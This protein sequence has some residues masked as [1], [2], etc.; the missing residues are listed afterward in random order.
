MDVIDRELQ[1]SGLRMHVR[2]WGGEGQPV[3]LVHGLAS[4]ARIWDLTAPYMIAAGLRVVAVDQRGHGQTAKPIEGYDYATITSDLRAA[5]VALRLKRPVVVGHSWGASVAVSYAVAHPSEVEGI[6]LLDGGFFDMSSSMTWE[7]AEVRMAPP[8]L[9][10]LTPEE[11]LERARTWGGALVWDEP[12]TAAVMGNFFVTSD[13]RLRPH[14]SRENH[15]R[16]LRAMYDEQPITMLQRVECPVL[17]AP[18][19]QAGKAPDDGFSAR[20]QDAVERALAAVPQA[21]VRWFEDT[22]HDVPL[23]RPKE[24]AE[25]IVAFAARVFGAAAENR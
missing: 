19:M 21:E 14:L 11:F 17:L 15:M 18:T 8:D 10:R 9:T 5:V 6:V 20:K 23:Q 7:Q 13:G 2:D 16:I 1:L 24:L 12:T 3:V 22:V 4:N 25:T